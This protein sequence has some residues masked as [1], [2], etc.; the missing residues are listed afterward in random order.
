MRNTAASSQRL[1]RFSFF[2]FLPLWW[3]IAVKQFVQ[4]DMRYMN[5]Q[6]IMWNE[7]SR[8]SL[9]NSL[10][11]FI[12]GIYKKRKK[13]QHNKNADAEAELTQCREKKASDWNQSESLHMKL[14]WIQ[15]EERNVVT[16][17]ICLVCGMRPTVPCLFAF[18][19]FFLFCI[20]VFFLDIKRDV[21]Q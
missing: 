8:L 2:F 20:F 16:Y 12:G 3:L 19:F 9:V 5:E 7:K 17:H 15:S 6:N 21:A 14:L 18:V 10:K 4:S 11:C 13:T 1:I